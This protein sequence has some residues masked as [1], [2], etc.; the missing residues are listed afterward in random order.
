MAADPSLE[1]QIRELY[2]DCESAAGEERWQAALDG[3]EALL[4]LLEAAGDRVGCGRVR[5]RMASVCEQAG[6]LEEA[7]AQAS[8]AE[9]LA[10]E[11]ADRG[12]LAAALHRR[13]HLVRM[14]DPASARELFLQSLAAGD[15]NLEARAVSRAMIGQID[16][17]SG[18]QAGGL[19]T[20]LEALEQM[21]PQ[22]AAFEHLVEHLAY[23][24]AK[25]PR[26]DYVRL[27]CRRIADAGL[28]DRLL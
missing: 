10:R 7:R 13:G 22:A 1:S 3:L 16:F 27:V 15:D 14:S 23:F 21:P 11:T 8:R 20:M 28:R 17:T 26:A 2:R 19:D 5:L 6:R 12:L 18:D 4:P 25:L 24:G 9:E